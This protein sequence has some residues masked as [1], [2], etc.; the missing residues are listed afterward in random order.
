M[1]AKTIFSIV[2]ISLVFAGFFQKLPTVEME[3]PFGK[4]VCEIDSVHAKTSFVFFSISPP[5]SLRR[6][7]PE[8]REV[9]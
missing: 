2:L 8:N 7:C 3:T 6:A 4:I 1:K 9:A 5:F